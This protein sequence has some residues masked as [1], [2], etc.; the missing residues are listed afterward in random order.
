MMTRGGFGPPLVVG[1][2]LVS[3]WLSAGAVHAEEPRDPTVY[4]RPLGNDPATLDP[5]RISDIYGRPVA[6]QIFDG[7]VQFDQT[8]T[9]TPSLARY[10][11]ASRDGLVWTFTLRQGIKFHHGRELEAADVVFSLT[12]LLDPKVKSGAADLF[13]GI[14]GAR[15]FR[16]GSATGV[17]GLRALDRHTVQVSLTE[18][19]TPFVSLLAMGHAKIV[20]RDAVEQL[21]DA[22]GSRPIGTGPFRFV[23]WERGKEI[24][25]EV[26]REYF[27]GAPRLG[28]VVY[29]VFPGES[30]DLM[31]RELERGALEESTVPPS[32]RGKINDPQFQ[33]V[34]RATFNVRFYGLNTRLRPLN[35]IRVRQAIAHAI[36]RE[37]ML[38]DIF[39]GRFLPSRGILPPGMPGFNPHLRV[40]S[41]APDRAR[42]L[43]RKAGFGE[44]KG[45]PA[46]TMWSSVKSERIERELDTVR[47]SL[48]A[49][50]IPLDIRYET[51]WPRFS[52]Q[53]SQGRLPLFVYAWYADVPDPDNFLFKLFHSRSTWNLTGYVNPVVDDL[54]L[55]ARRERDLARR[56]DLYRRAEQTIVDEAPVVPIWHY[57]FERLYQSYVR[58]VEVNGLGDPYIPLRKIWLEERR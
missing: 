5:A 48:G 25:L 14:Q 22:F 4:R 40:G 24:V 55:Q 32:C 15:E 37:S 34:R 3:A 56:I 11:R 18:A 23:R 54:L 30:S 43:L 13:G 12:R 6:E 42:E 57:P 26:N 49:V 38:Q 19:Y 7:L 41:Y 53:L 20:P 33:F 17:A 21:G 1:A 27:E 16:D 58:S 28:R 29:R 31:C 9:I 10:W 46:L 35:D 8:L 47:R 39:G 44:G 45:F 52:A 51:D 2:V 36:N 50:G